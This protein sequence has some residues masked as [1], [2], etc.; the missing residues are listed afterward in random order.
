RSA[1]C[2]RAFTTASAHFERNFNTECKERKFNHERARFGRGPAKGAGSDRHSGIDGECLAAGSP[3][4]L[5][6]WNR[7]RDRVDGGGNAAVV[8]A[9]ADCGEDHRTPA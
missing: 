3:A 9:T 1:R 5:D 4:N 6:S 8:D 7:V 2:G